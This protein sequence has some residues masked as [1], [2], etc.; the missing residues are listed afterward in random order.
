M[1]FRGAYKEPQHV[2]ASRGKCKQ[3]GRIAVLG[4]GLCVDC[5]D[6]A[7]KPLAQIQYRERQKA[8]QD[9]EAKVR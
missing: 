9:Y 2:T 6:K 8:K 7:G 1:G 5:F 4:D 3:C